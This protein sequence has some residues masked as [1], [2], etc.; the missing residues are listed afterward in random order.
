MD[1]SSRSK[2]E[3]INEEDGAVLMIKGVTDPKTIFDGQAL[4]EIW[5]RATREPIAH[6]ILTK[7]KVRQLREYLERVLGER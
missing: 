1:E 4:F 2:I 3:F 7:E 6:V 5:D